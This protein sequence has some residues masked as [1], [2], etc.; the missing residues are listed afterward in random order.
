ML[1]QRGRELGQISDTP[2]AYDAPHFSLL[3]L[4]GG[5]G[6]RIVVR[7]EG[8]A[9]SHNGNRGSCREFA[10]YT[11]YHKAIRYSLPRRASFPHYLPKCVCLACPGRRVPA[12]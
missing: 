8:D 5:R 2:P 7:N 4:H 12:D 10:A 1:H 9:T 11:L 6:W 3:L